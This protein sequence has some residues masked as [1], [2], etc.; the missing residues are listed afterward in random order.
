MRI[1]GLH[2]SVSSLSVM[3]LWPGLL[4]ISGL[5]YYVRVMQIKIRQAKTDDVAVLQS[6][7]TVS[8]RGLSQG[9][10]ND[11][12]IESALIHIFGVDT[13]LIDDST[14]YVAEVDEQIVGCGGWSKRKT[15]YGGDQAKAPD[16]DLLL[17]PETEPARIRAFFIHPEWARQGIGRRI[18]EVCEHAAQNEHFKTFELAATLPGVPLYKA[19]GYKETEPID[20]ALPEGTTLPVI[21]MRKQVGE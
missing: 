8:V 10:Y 5:I 6:L 16:V 17:N 21:L 14:Y 7:I 9:Y 13:Q 3:C 4:E 18:I 15:L 19:C 20:I 11:Q 12:Q 2:P 1:Q